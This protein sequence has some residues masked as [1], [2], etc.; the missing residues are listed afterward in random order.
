MLSRIALRVCVQEA[1]RGR[2][3]VGANVLDSQFS[4]LDLD[5]DGHLRTEQE[6]PFVSVYTEEGQI[7]AGGGI[8]LLGQSSV[9]LVIEAG[10]ASSM[11]VQ[12][13]ETGVMQLA[14][15]LPDTDAGMEFTLDLIM[16]QVAH[17]L[18][19]SGEI[20]AELARSFIS[21]ISRI[22][23]ARIGGKSNGVRIAGHELRLTGQLVQ[24]PLPGQD[25]AGTPFERFLTALAASG[26]PELVK[27]RETIEQALAG[28][29]LDY[30]A[31]RKLMGWA[32]ADAEAIGAGSH[33]FVPA[34][35]DPVISQVSVER[36]R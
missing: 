34:G 11:G 6:R 31:V 33:A 2:T 12:D 10:I 15:G 32:D 19:A 14:S 8:E 1:L 25:L 7:A 18:T 35:E 3:A 20:W 26:R 27:L 24:D 13:P 21:G 17:A 28:A 9:Q 29:A 30:T 16:H 23:R 22:D 4:A 36:D 5:A